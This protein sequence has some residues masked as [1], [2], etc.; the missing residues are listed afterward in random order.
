MTASL[1]N[2]IS[3]WKLIFEE[4]RV[5]PPH[6]QNSRLTTGPTQAFRLLLKQVE[7]LPVKQSE[8]LKAD[9]HQLRVTLFD[10][11]HQHFFGRTWKSEPHQARTTNQSTTVPFNEV[12]YFHTPLCLSSVVAVVEL[13]SPSTQNAVGVGFGLLQ[14]FS[15][16]PDSGPPHGEGRLSL[17]HGTPRA[18]LHPTLRDPLQMNAVLSVMEGTQLLYSLQPHPALRPIMHLL[19]PNVLVSGHDLIP[20]VAPPTDGTDAL[21]RPRLLPEFPCVLDRVCVSLAPSMEVFETNLLQMLNNDRHSTRLGMEVRSVV[22]QERRLHVGVHNGWGWVERPQVLVLELGSPGAKGSSSLRQDSTDILSPSAGPVLLLNASVELKMMRHPAFSVVFQLEYVFS[23]PLAGEGKMTSTA[24]QRAVFMQCVRWCVWS[25]FSHPGGDTESICLSLQGGTL[26]NPCAVMVYT[27]QTDAEKSVIKFRFSS[28]TEGATSSTTL[29]AV[30]LE[31]PQPKKLHPT[32]Q[33]ES[34]LDLETSP[35]RSTHGPAL[36]LS[37]LAATSR[38]PTMS[39]TTGSPWQQQL[40]ALLAPS[41]MASAHQLSHVEHPAAGSIAHLEV[42]VMEREEMRDEKEEECNLRELTF[43]PVHAPVITLGTHIPCSSRMSSRSSLAHLFSSCFPEI[44][45]GL[46]QI[47]EVMDPTEPVYFDPQREEADPLQTN[48]LILQFLAFTRVRQAGMNANWPNSIHFTFQLYRFPPVTTQRLQLLEP[49]PRPDYPCVLSLINK[50]GTPSSDCPGLQLQYCVDA[51]VLKPGERVWFLRY[52]ALHSLQIDVWDSDTLLLIGSAAVELKHLLRQ[53]RPAVQVNH[54]LEVITTEYLQDTDLVSEHAARRRAIPAIN[55]YTTVR[56]RLHVR[57]GSVGGTMQKSLSS[58]TLFPPS[59]SHIIQ[60]SQTPAGFRG[61]SLSSNSIQTLNAQNSKRAQRLPEI[62]SELAKLLQSRMRE[63][64]GA[65]LQGWSEA[66]DMR[67]RKLDRMAAVRQHEETA[68]PTMQE[69]SISMRRKEDRIAHSQDLRLIEAYR[70]R[71][72]AESITNMLSKAITTTHT[73]YAT[74][75]TAEFF[76]FVLKNPFNVPQTV[77]IESDDPELSVIVKTEEWR[78]FKDLTNTSTPME[79]DMFHL[80]DGGPVV[81][82]YLRP[83]ESIHVPLKYQTFLSGHALPSQ[84]QS[85]L[86]NAKSPH[87]ARKQQSNTVL[88]KCIKV[89][90]RAEDGQPLAICQVNVEPTP[91]VIDQTFRFY[92]PELTFLK[93]AI[94]LPPTTHSPPDGCAR[95]QVHC[96][97]PTVICHAATM[98][99]GEPQDIYLKVPGAASPQIKKFFITVFTDPWLASPTQTWQVYVHYLQRLDIMCVCGALSWHSLLLRGTQVIRKV[100]CHTSHPLEL[101]VDPEEVFALPSQGLQDIQLGVGVLR[102]GCSFR[103]LNVVDVDT[104]QLVAA[105]LLCISCKQPLIS[106]AFEIQVPVAGGRGSNKKISFTNPYPS[107]RGFK[108]YSDHPDLLQ[109]KEERFQIEG[110]ESYSIGLRFAPSQ[111]PGMEE[112]LIFINDLE[113]KN[114]E[115]Y[116]VKVV[117]R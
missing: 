81:Q 90:F 60:P 72:K 93:K 85:S 62:D 59:R 66:E 37:Q 28:D 108:L 45:D 26:P 56:G 73:L 23:V 96:S 24:V 1:G 107:S 7:G 39:H 87:F 110:G 106:R 83:K 111:S 13:V 41:P 46:G 18:L 69:K 65:L 47:A 19:P 76:E 55:V 58:S 74:L 103:Y 4:K 92:H 32:S 51:G 70:E 78:Y 104:R 44:R 79:A 91:H 10:S 53:G 102:S 67:Q 101:Q 15:S 114:E 105:W 95:L 31:T 84:D 115:T 22:V 30:P 27:Q 57:L 68:S 117:Y 64:G 38:Y 61:G 99:P 89:F 48:T 33:D 36:S 35:L 49:E 21:R 80:K 52:L 12:I 116:C 98:A 9:E 94:R 25:P 34:R 97:D 88:A 6:S 20:G 63:V 100:K 14:L 50:D 75:G 8:E 54:E 16:R 86:K 82:V 3:E 42:S 2:A 5:I 40:P 77:T 109:F 113:D 112:I 11:E 17:F 71:C 29:K 43:T